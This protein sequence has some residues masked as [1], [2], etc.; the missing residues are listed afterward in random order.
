MQVISLAAEYSAIDPV[1]STPEN[2]N[3]EQEKATV[4]RTS[5]EPAAVQQ[6]DPPPSGPPHDH[7]NAPRPRMTTQPCKVKTEN[8]HVLLSLGVAKIPF[9]GRCPP[10]PPRPLIFS[11][12]GGFYSLE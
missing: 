11:G 10:A 4:Q 7:G 3:N 9:A 8:T 2:C 12:G 1:L 5:Q 6:A